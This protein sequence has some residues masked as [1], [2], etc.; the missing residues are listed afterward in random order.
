MTRSLTAGSTML[1]IGDSITDC[2]R[3]RDDPA[4]LGAGY[5]AMAA[6]LHA[7]RRPG[8]R[9][10]FVNR[11]I[12][13]DRVV[14]LRARW[15]RD[16]LALSPDTV[17]VLVGIN[18]VWRRYEGDDPTT[19]EDFEE[20]YRFILGEAAAHG[21]RLLLI[22]PFLLPARPEL[23]TRREDLDPKISA[24]RRLA[25]EFGAALVPA[26][27]LLAQAVA[28]SDVQEWSSDGVLHLTPA[29]HA[30][31]AQAWLAAAKLDTAERA[32]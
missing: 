4:S 31:L 3:D 24:V 27:G 13:G 17:S 18:D 7:A 21:A 26:D 22:E 10:Q 23:W 5:A 9:I 1:F 25:Y 8:Q 20:D 29:G 2:G 30:L 15:K 32:R 11:G 14:D 6:G 28:D 16:C 12:G 19:V